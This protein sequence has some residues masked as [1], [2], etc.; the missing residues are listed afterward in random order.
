M[1][2]L[3]V[4]RRLRDVHAR[5]M[6]ARGELAV[7]DEQFQVASE[8]AED[9]RLRALVAETPLAEHEYTEARRH[10]DVMVRAKT[11]LSATV[12]SLERRQDELLS[13]VGTGR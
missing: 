8:E 9:L 1:Q 10:V 2:P 12:E 6:S 3:L 13:Q 7:L 11:A 4:E 5:L